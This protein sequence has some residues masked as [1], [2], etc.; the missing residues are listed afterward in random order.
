MIVELKTTLDDHIP[1]YLSSSKTPSSQPLPKNQR[2]TP[3]YTAT[4]IRLGIGYSAV[5]VA[6]YIFYLDYILKIK[7]EN[8][9][10]VTALAVVAYFILNGALT[11][12]LWFGERGLI[13]TGSRTDG[14][15]T[16]TLKL[17]SHPPHRK[18]EPTY[19][20]T[21]SWTVEGGRSALEK[22]GTLEIKAP[23]TNFFAADS[24]FVPEKFEAWL[25][26]TIP[27]T[28]RSLEDLGKVEE[29][30]PQEA[31]LIV[32][33]TEQDADGNVTVKS[34]TQGLTSQ[35]GDTIVLGGGST[36]S[37]AYTPSTKKRGRPKKSETPKPQ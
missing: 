6:L 14:L 2:F 22:S 32:E 25:R 37:D 18:Y 17:H 23:F 27:V 13:F 5:A 29:I 12:W 26:K 30:D 35:R 31:D 36:S 34:S 19:R 11:L 21:A 16:V 1:I 9:K 24:H 33:S 8:V 7:F 10:G 3:S 20:F 15:S 4:Y 28:A